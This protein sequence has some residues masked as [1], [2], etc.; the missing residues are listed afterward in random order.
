MDWICPRINKLVIEVVS[1]FLE[2]ANQTHSNY[3]P[4]IILRYSGLRTDVQQKKNQIFFDFRS[5]RY[6]IQLTSGPPF[7]HFVNLFFDGC[8]KKVSHGYSI[9]LVR[10]R[11]KRRSFFSVIFAYRVMV[12]MVFFSHL[13]YGR[14]PVAMLLTI[15][16]NE[17][18]LTRRFESLLLHVHSDDPT[19]ISNL[20]FKQQNFIEINL[21]Y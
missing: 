10:Y 11:K 13:L 17:M 19:E 3:S 20:R 5:I 14:P 21:P 1:E 16:E 12:K 4:D 8:A 2:L 7:L 6:K 9:T 18:W 15:T